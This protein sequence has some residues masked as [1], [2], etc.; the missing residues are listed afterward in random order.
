MQVHGN[1][2]KLGWRCYLHFNA[3]WRVSNRNKYLRAMLRVIKLFKIK[4][5]PKG[6]TW[7]IIS[8][9]VS[10]ISVHA[11]QK[12]EKQLMLIFWLACAKIEP[13]YFQ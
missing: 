7:S 5:T 6:T 8:H 4:W 12:P 2:Y 1:T 10:G 13:A 11:K 9:W 3:L